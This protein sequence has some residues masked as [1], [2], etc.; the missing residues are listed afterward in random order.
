MSF[1][2]AHPLGADLLTTLV[3]LPTL[4]AL[5]LALFPGSSKLAPKAIG[6]ATSLLTFGVSVLLYRGFDTATSAPVAFAIDRPWIPRFGIRYQLGVD[7]LAL[8]LVLLTTILTVSVLLVS[9]GQTIEKLKGYV[10]A[11][12]LLETGM[13]GSLVALDTL[14]FYVFWEVMLVPMYFIIGVWGGKRRIYAAM[15]FILF[16]LVGSLLMFVAILYTANV[17][18]NAT[19]LQSFS[20]A[21][22][23]R[24]ASSG[25]WNL[26]P[27]TEALLFGAFALAFLV[28]VP[29]W[30]LHTWL[31][32]AHVEAPTGGSIILAGVLLKLGTYGLLRFAYPLFPHAAARYGPLLAVLALVG[33]VYGA[34]VAAA[35]KDMKK[36]VAYSSVS[37]LA[38][39][40]LGIVAGTGA[41]LSG[42]VFQMV[43][44]GL[45]TG[46]LF[47]L[48]GVL[49]ARRHTREM[50][51]YGGVA[52][53][54][55][56]TTAL[57]LIAT[58][59]SVGLPG[60]NGFVGEFLLLGGVFQ[61]NVAWAAIA[62][63]GMIFG[64][65]YLLTLVQKVF[66]GAESVAAN[67]SLTD[68]NAWELAGAFP[69]VVLIVLLGIFPRPLLALVDGS[70]KTLQRAS[71]P[72]AAKGAPP[73]GDA[74]FR[75]FESHAVPAARTVAAR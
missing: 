59:G 60:L 66:W 35:Q 58:L 46:L 61:V 68:I 13:L 5:V 14:L 71:T 8:A 12:L 32:D 31:P 20:L 37:H 65:I 45:T 39:V 57:F 11:F 49:Y 72:A 17:H 21:D 56:V 41:A 51:D 52:A 47:L 48:V 67:R 53:R 24:A 69:L 36:L 4:G 42:A 25:A 15:K 10:V 16:T 26:A 27:G 19:G 55:P 34:L 74:A 54:V 9:C 22:W 75:R 2:N 63:T 70:V 33:I 23:T 73:A 30:P 7:G 28:K 40:V 64:A 18:L 50:A 44:H 3:F 29:L 38:L 6:L 43:G 1:A 62:A